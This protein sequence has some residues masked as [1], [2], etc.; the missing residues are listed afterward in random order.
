M[1]TLSSPTQIEE[2][3]YFYDTDCGGVVHNL[4]YLRIIEKARSI[5]FKERLSWDASVMN[6]TQVFPA[7][8]R[9]EVDYIKPARLGDRLRITA[10]FEKIER[11]RITC[12]F[13]IHR[14]LEAE[15]DQL[16]VKCR[17]TLVLIQMP[18]AKPRRVPSEWLT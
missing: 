7:L 15:S 13:E 5:L 16:S 10:R 12:T 2:E 14:Q 11:I 4:A 1:S 6:E 8:T 9:T 3:V 18:D 17:Q